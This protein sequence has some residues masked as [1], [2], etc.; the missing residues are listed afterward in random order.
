V[1]G[2]VEPLLPWKPW[3]FHVTYLVNKAGSFS[4]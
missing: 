2:V 1:L 4:C 3:K